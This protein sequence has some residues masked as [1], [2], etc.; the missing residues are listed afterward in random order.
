[1]QDWPAAGSVDTG[2]SLHIS[3]LERHRAQVAQPRVASPRIVEALDV[4]EDVG[5]GGI[6]GVVELLGCPLGLH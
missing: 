3:V 1:M 4:V 5:T 6:T 2:L